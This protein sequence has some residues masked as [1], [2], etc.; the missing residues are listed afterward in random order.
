MYCAGL[1]RARS[2][3]G[4]RGSLKRVREANIVRERERERRTALYYFV[5]V[6][7]LSSETLQIRSRAVNLRSIRRNFANAETHSVTI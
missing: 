1:T 2:R 6:Y 5:E 7:R 3:T 4:D